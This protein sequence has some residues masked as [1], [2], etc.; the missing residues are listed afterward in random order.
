MSN[1]LTCDNCGAPTAYLASRCAYCQAPLTWHE[2]PELRAG[3]VLRRFD[4]RRGEPMPGMD[5]MPGVELRPGAGAMIPIEAGRNAYL[6]ARVPRRDAAVSLT[7]VALHESVTLGID[8]RVTGIGRARTAY[9]VKISPRLRA[10]RIARILNTGKSLYL[11][12]LRVM[13]TVEAIAGVGEPNVLDVRF[14]DSVISVRVNGAHL[15]SFVDARYLYG[16]H[17]FSVGA[18]HAPGQALIAELEVREIG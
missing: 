1:A 9:T 12:E 18:L 13:E 17:G 6:G 14:A 10:F 11:E 3:A 8:F 2:V 7:A 4:L 16:D 15:G 5:Q